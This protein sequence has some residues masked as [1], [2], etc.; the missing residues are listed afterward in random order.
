MKKIII[1][2]SILSVGLLVSAGA[3]AYVENQN[4]PDK[5]FQTYLQ[6]SLSTEKLSVVQ[7]MEGTGAKL[8]LNGQI[9]AKNK[10]YTASG[11]LECSGKIGEHAIVVKATVSLDKAASH[12]RI[13][14]LTGKVADPDMGDVDLGTVY[15]GAKGKWYEASKEDPAVKAQ[16]DSG[17]FVSNSILIAPGYD[18]EKIS[19]KL[20]DSGAFSYKSYKKVGNNFVYEFTSNKALYLNVLKEEFPNLRNP[21]LILDSVFAD[22]GVLDST[23]TV[24]EDGKLISEKLTST[25]ECATL[26]EGFTGETP[27]N[28]ATDFAGTSTVVDEAAVK[29]DRAINPKP[30][31]QIGED[32]V[33]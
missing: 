22:K 5:V 6:K 15:A 28:I 24:N 11:D 13:N 20:I 12:V 16:I 3:Y 4:K 19:K 18:A 21:D 23:V 1:A 14:E 25:N 30:I 17:V 2:A 31:D 29:I 7:N 26:I 32:L 9:N 27:T 33:F 10:T 8:V